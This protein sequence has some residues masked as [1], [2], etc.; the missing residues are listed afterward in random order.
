MS[1][2]D[3]R[4][5]SV[6]HRLEP[7]MKIV[8]FAVFIALAVSLNKTYTLFAALIAAVLF[9]ILGK[10]GIRKLFKRLFL[11]FPFELLIIIFI[12]FT[13][14]GQEVVSFLGLSVTVEGLSRALVLFLRMET[15][16][17]I[18][19]VLFLTTGA[20]GIINGL[21]GLK[22]PNIIVALMEFILRYI[23]L[24]NQEIEKMNIARKAR[25]YVKGK[26]LFD[27]KTFKTV[28]DIIGMGLIRSY[29]RSKKIY[30]SMLSRGYNGYTAQYHSHKIKLS[31]ILLAALFIITA[32]TIFI[33]D[34]S[35]TI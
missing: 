12:P 21:R 6:I 5:K 34:R 30:N 33:L 1:C 13:V 10:V 19:A 32:A 7:R 3:D 24:F 23:D 16:C 14:K 25:G 18:M 17:V 26:H 15:A 8:S 20:N 2:L 22:F 27:K 4:N 35:L 11:A 29:D 9:S 31:D 28:G